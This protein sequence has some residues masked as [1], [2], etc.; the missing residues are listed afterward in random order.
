VTAR[1]E[2]GLKLKWMGLLTL[3][4]I[5]PLIITDLTIVQVCREKVGGSLIT[6]QGIVLIVGVLFSFF[7]ARKLALP[8]EQSGNTIDH[9]KF[10]KDISDRR[11]M[12]EELRK[13]E[14]RYWTIIENIQDGY[15]ETDIAGN[16]TFVNDAECSNM[17]YAREELIGI[18]NRQYS[19]QEN[20][21]KVYQAFNRVYRTGEPTKGFDWEIIR[22]DGTKRYIE[23]SVSL[24]K[25]AFGKPVGFRGIIR[26]ITDRK[27]IEEQ[28]FQAEK[29][30]AVGESC[31][32]VS[33]GRR[34]G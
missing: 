17:G 29:L 3:L 16:Y 21:K 18:N 28:L 23:A 31:G 33:P 19:D 26:D 22:K 10:L 11:R 1:T 2:R 30:R 27:R 32:T 34:S 6:V 7:L 20:A 24:R 12:E 8:F 13:P 14:E 5:L 15:F 9:G 25:D 4:T